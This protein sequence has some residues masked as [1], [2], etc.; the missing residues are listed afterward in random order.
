MARLYIIELR[1]DSRERGFQHGEQLRAPI[2]EAV[3]FYRQ[4]FA[5]HLKIDAAEM[6]RRAARFI[7]PTGE[8]APSLMAE[9]EGIAVGSGQTLE[10]IFALS[11][12][13][14]ITFEA[15]AL[16]DC[17]NLFVGPD[18]SANGHVLLGQSW[19]WRPEVMDFRAVIRSRCDDQPD[20]IMV[21]ECGQPGKYGFNAS[22][23]G[24]VSAGLSCTEKRATGEQLF[25]VLGRQV[26]ARDSF[27]ESVAVAESAP[28]MATINM[29]VAEAD[30]NAVN[31]EF[32]PTGVFKRDL[33]RDHSFWHTNHCLIAD[34]PSDFEN[35]LVRGERWAELTASEESISPDL[36]QRWLSD[37][38]PGRHSICQLPDPVMAHTTTYLQTLCSIVMDL[39]EKAL[40]VSDGPSCRNPYQQFR[41]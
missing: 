36:V 40:W 6:R 19:D 30:G 39:N 20:H 1:G 10:D 22:G 35:S 38:V 21:T 14:E 7:A 12:R 9:Y 33:A 27:E 5:T 26:L 4:F 11:A 8:V 3:D 23:L 13:Y 34:E 32:T 16:G 24:V 41:L 18:A 28:P 2:Q 31:F 15:A 29:L 17:S 25:V 37:R